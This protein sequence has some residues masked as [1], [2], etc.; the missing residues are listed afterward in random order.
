MHAVFLMNRIPSKLL[1][2]KS[3]Y[4]L[5]YGTIPDLSNIKVFGSLCFVSTLPQLRSKL[6]ARA[7]KC[8]FLGFKVGIEAYLSDYHCK[9][10]I[11]H[12]IPYQIFD[13]ISYS[14]LSLTH[15]AFFIPLSL[16][17]EPSSYDEASTNPS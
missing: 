10:I 6:D 11:K 15:N 5:L 2:D 3:T 1:H 17:A 13:Y 7:K 16:E 14:S 9:A 8:V 12:T 4:E